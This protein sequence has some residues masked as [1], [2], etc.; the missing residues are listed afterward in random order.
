MNFFCIH[1]RL[2]NKLTRSK[3][4]ARES[5]GAGI[6]ENMIQQ[7]VVMSAKQNDSLFLG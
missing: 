4:F 3:I 5:N 2:V 1:I 7:I 6:K